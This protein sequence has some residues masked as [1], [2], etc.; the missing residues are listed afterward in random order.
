[1]V[2]S[3]LTVFSVDDLQQWLADYLSRRA[4]EALEKA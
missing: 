4:K 1:M 2:K 3:I